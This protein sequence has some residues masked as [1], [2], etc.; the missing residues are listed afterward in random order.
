MARRAEHLSSEK[1]RSHAFL[2]QMR[3][4]FFGGPLKTVGFSLVSHTL[5]ERRTQMEN[6]GTHMVS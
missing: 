4:S 3:V 1:K 6:H 5:K 2:W